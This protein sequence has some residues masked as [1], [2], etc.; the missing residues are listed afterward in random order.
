MQE[1]YFLSIAAFHPLRYTEKTFRYFRDSRERDMSEVG[2]RTYLDKIEKDY[3][4]GIATE[5]SYRG[6]LKE[7]LKALGAGSTATNEPKRSKCG[8]P[9]Y[10]IGR[11]TGTTALTIGYVEAK[12]IGEPLDKIERDEQLG[13]YRNSLENLILTDYLEFRWY[14]NGEKRM[15]ARLAT[16]RPDKQL[17]FEKDG[18]RAVA[19][20]LLNFL[21]R[22]PEPIR[23]PQDL[24]KR[25]ARLSRMIRAIVVA[26][27]E[28]KEVSPT[29]LDLSH[30]F[31]AVP[32][33]QI[34]HPELSTI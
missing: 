18:A 16:S 29:I 34:P 22:H 5:H 30:P 10:V 15:T 1:F 8:A 11:D 19:D 4:Q 23:K 31:H 25:M 3:R 20:L 7:L 26:A 24:A 12:N 32:L 2:L 33:P 6:T 17:S 27:F 9:D 28:K 14:V 21:G 13:R